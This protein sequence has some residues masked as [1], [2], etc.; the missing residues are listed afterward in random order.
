[1]TKYH[2]DLINRL[3]KLDKSEVVIVLQDIFDRHPELADHIADYAQSAPSKDG[4]LV[5][6]V[7]NAYYDMLAEQIAK[8]DAERDDLEDRKAEFFST[9]FPEDDDDIL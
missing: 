6:S 4:V 3:D 9:Y 5:G 1:M 7:A 2:K 8:E